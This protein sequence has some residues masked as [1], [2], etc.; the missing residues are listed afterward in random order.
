MQMLPEKFLVDD[1]YKSSQ[2][3]SDATLKKRRSYSDQFALSIRQSIAACIKEHFSP[4]GSETIRDLFV[5][6]DE[7]LHHFDEVLS[8]MDVTTLRSL[9]VIDSCLSFDESRMLGKFQLRVLVLSH[10]HLKRL[11]RCIFEISSLEVLKIDHNNLEE[12]PDEVGNLSNLRTFCCD[13]QRPRLRILPNSITRLDQLQVLS[14]CDNR[15]ETIALVATLPNLRVLRCN[16]NHIVRLPTQIVNLSQ[17]VWLDVSHNRISRIPVSLLDLVRRLCRFDYF[18]LHLQPAH[19]RRSKAALLANLE[20]ECFLTNALSKKICANDL[21]MVVFGETG[22]GKA[23]LVQALKDSKGVARHESKPHKYPVRI[24]QFDLTVRSGTDSSSRSVNG[25][26]CSDAASKSGFSIDEWSSDAAS[27]FVTCVVFGGDHLD[28]FTS[29]VRADIYL[30]LIDLTSLEHHNGSQ[31]LVA[32]HVARLQMWLQSLYELSPDVPVL[33][34]GTHAD[35]AKSVTFYDVCT[36]LDGLMA[37]ARQRHRVRYAD[38]RCHN[39]LLCCEKTMGGRH[40]LTKSRSGHLGFADLSSTHTSRTPSISGHAGLPPQEELSRPTDSSGL[41]F[42]HVVGYYEVDS[43]RC[44]PKDSKKTNFSIEQL[45]SAILRMALSREGIPVEWIAFSRQLQATSSANPSRPITCMSLEDVVSMARSF[46]ISESQVPLMLQHLHRRGQLVYFAA[47][48]ALLLQLVVIDPAWLLDVAERLLAAQDRSR[49]DGAQILQWLKIEDVDRQFQK[50]VSTRFSLPHWLLAALERLGYCATLCLSPTGE[51]VFFFPR[52]LELGPPSLDVWPDIPELDERQVAFDVSIR[53]VSTRM[54]M[55]F[56]MSVNLEGRKTLEI[57]PDPAPVFLSHCVVF[58]SALDVGRC[59]DCQGLRNNTRMH[60]VC[61]AV[62]DSM[63][64]DD[65]LHKVFIG[66]QPGMCTVRIKVR[67]TS[68]CCIM[69]M[70]LRFLEQFIDDQGGEVAADPLLLLDRQGRRSCFYSCSSADYSLSAANGSPVSIECYED[71]N[72]SLLCPKCVLLRDVR[73]ERISH[74]SM[75]ARNK[76]VCNKWHNLGSWTRAVTGDY[77]FSSVDRPLSLTPTALPEYEHPRLAL[78]LPPSYDVSLKEWYLT[79]R[80]RFLEGLEVHFLC[81]NPTYWHMMDSFGLRLLCHSHSA[82]SSFCRKDAIAGITSALFGLALPMIQLF[83]GVNEHSQ[84]GRLLAPVV[85]ELMRMYD[86][87]RCVD[88]QTHDDAYSW[89]ARNKDRLVAML[90]KVLAN[91]VV[92][93][94]DGPQQTDVYVKAGASLSP[95]DVLQT[96]SRANRY[97][98]GRFLRLE[99]SSGRFGPLRP[100]YVGREIRWVCDTHYEELRSMCSLQ[101]N[102]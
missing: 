13:S 65:V 52:L 31:H 36:T 69:K 73:P 99:T 38:T 64:H 76:A 20:L 71:R 88:P 32:R 89:L 90:T 6:Q 4:V 3:D 42:P 92:N 30:L 93:F 85:L 87:L 46:D 23:T 83:Q 10:A 26:P 37:K 41:S 24:H 75:T 56:L 16:A 43:K 55:E 66:L 40:A 101:F 21:V 95:D 47:D 14:F 34:V 63:A 5:L 98:L 74:Q 54:F 22:A 86:Y 57:V 62:D 17:L 70:A 58:F 27:R 60:R 9:Y 97:E 15:I 18:N 1:I 59:D 28:V 49:A 84:S 51:R 48:D 50:G 82:S 53:T 45:K 96:P 35:L 79:S 19:V 39:C 94:T 2:L 91:A 25:T 29:S 44:Y 8:R 7:G 11:P 80:M 72:F 78:L 100:L 77:R 61:K 67:G 12:V 33:I 102:T 68:P 81:E